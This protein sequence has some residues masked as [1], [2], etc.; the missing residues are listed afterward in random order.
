MI[1]GQFNNN[2][3]VAS[4]RLLQLL[5]VACAS[6]A[7]IGLSLC[8]RACSLLLTDCRDVGYCAMKVSMGSRYS[9]KTR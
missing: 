7:F 4:I 6:L 1:H 2:M 5:I 8:R 9:G 3:C